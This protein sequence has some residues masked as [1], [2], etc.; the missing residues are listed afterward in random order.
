MVAPITDLRRQDIQFEWG[1]AQEAAFL[2][3]A[4]LCT[5]DNTPILRHCNLDRPAVLETDVCDFAI[6]SA[7]CILVTGCLQE[8]LS[9]YEV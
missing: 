7:N 4:V 5:S 6:A 8:C 2:T 9:G 1:Q 3:I